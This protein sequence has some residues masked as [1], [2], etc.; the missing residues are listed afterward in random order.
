MPPFLL[1]LSLGTNTMLVPGFQ[2]VLSPGW[3]RVRQYSRAQKE[4][5]N[6][7]LP[8]SLFPPDKIRV[9]PN[10]AVDYELEVIILKFVP[11]CLKEQNSLDSGT[12]FLARSCFR[13]VWT[14]IAD[15][16]IVG[17]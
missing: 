12:C 11:L 3:V 4:G 10:W 14:I 13:H 7:R 1:A 2:R 5:N 8:P 16:K 9:G 6:V 15:I 17:S